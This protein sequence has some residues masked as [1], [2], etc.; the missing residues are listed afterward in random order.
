M[1]R[2][3]IPTPKVSIPERTIDSWTSIYL[4]RRL[5]HMRLWAPTVRGWDDWDFAG[6]LGLAV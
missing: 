4:A 5:P 3:P 1:S 2:I 6:D